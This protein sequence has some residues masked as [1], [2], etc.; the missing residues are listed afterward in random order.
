[1]YSD[2]MEITYINFDFIN[3]C[4]SREIGNKYLFFL[5]SADDLDTVGRRQH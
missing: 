4:N 2:L 1:M 5:I 3:N